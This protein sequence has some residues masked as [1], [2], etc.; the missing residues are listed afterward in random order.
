MDSGSLELALVFLLAAVLAVPLFKRFGLGAVLAYLVTGVMLGPHE[1]ALVR[2]PA[3]VLAASE[4]G[5]VM[6]L[7]VIGLELSLP[8]LKLM[9]RPI[10]VVGGLQV[11]FCGAAL[12]GLALAAGLAWKAALVVGLGLAL[13]STAVG[14]QLL[15]ERKELN[16]EHGRLAFAILLF[17]DLVAIPL[18]AAIPLL[19][20]AKSSGLDASD[21]LRAVAL[22]AALVVGGRYLLRHMFRTIARTDLPEVFTGAALLVV[23]GSAWLM[24]WAGLSAGLGAFLAGVLL[25]ESEYRH[26]LEAQIK[27]FEGLLL[28]LFFMA[29]GMGIDVQRILAEPV[30]IGLGVASL[31]LVKSALLFTLGKQPGRLDARGAWL[32]AGVLALGGE[33]A[34]VVFGEAF[35]AK[36]LDAA[37]RDRLIAIVSLSM[38]VTPLLLMLASK[39]M[40]HRT[41]AQRR[42]YDSIPEDRHPQV[43]VAGFGR[44]GQIVARLLRA[45]GT[46]YIAI[47]PDIEQVKLSRSMSGDPIYYGDPTR[48]ALLR[49]AGA[50]RI[51]VFVVAINGVEAS[52]RMVRLVRK[53]YPQA[54]V[55]A[56]ARDR[57]HAWQLVDLGAHALRETYGSSLEMGREVLIT[58]GMPREQAE[59]R[60][61][62]FREWDESLLE[63]QRML[64]DDEDALLQA[65]RD[66]REE[67]EGLFAA[68]AKASADHASAANTPAPPA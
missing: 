41:A 51:K 65:T 29:V 56:R 35:R 6:L 32:L 47:D 18:L 8:R 67:L 7:F 61:Q 1:L 3:R 27:P 42:E 21:V 55:F 60:A 9:R 5:V 66:A 14:L 11:L 2:D 44:F 4:L 39:L 25:A 24:Q 33:F 36:L 10:F 52:L 16:S 17:Q 49:S 59:D 40:P 30:L 31:L 19:G 15:A 50:A 46:A 22:I 57:R 58:L 38:A 37:T 62:R 45:Q 53:H 23:L 20:K 12:G 34:F 26:E 13:S 48:L 43:L 54:K 68:D 64:Q 28:G 63:S